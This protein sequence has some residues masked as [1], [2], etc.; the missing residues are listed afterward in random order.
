MVL[1]RNNHR[2]ERRRRVLLEE[3][4]LDESEAR[5]AGQEGTTRTS[6]GCAK[7]YTDSA[8]AI[9]QPRVVDLIPVRV[10]S[11]VVLTLLVTCL[12]VGIE[13]LYGYLALG[14][15][16]VR[17]GQVPA[18]DLAA[19][20][21]IANWFA[22]GLLLLAAGLGC[23]T[24]L[25][26][27]HRTDDYRG[28]YRMWYWVVPLVVLASVNQTVDWGTSLRIV[29][30]A[31]VGI[32]D[33][34]DATLIWAAIATVLATAVAVRLVIEMHASRLAVVFVVT[35][36]SSAGL[37]QAMQ[38]GWILG[39]DG[40]FQVMAA[41]G[42]RLL[43]CGTL[44][45]SFC[46]YSRHVHLE[47]H[48]QIVTKK[49]AQS[50]PRTRARRKSSAVDTATIAPSGSAKAESAKPALPKSM[51][52]KPASTKATEPALAGVQATPA[53]STSAAQRLAGMKVRVDAS[54]AE[55]AKTPSAPL[56]AE[57]IKRRVSAP[58]VAEKAPALAASHQD[59]DDSADGDSDDPNLSR[60]E[61]RR[62][63]KLQKRERRQ[64]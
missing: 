27:R 32:P 57:A 62:L 50:A 13:A 59:R 24:F 9:Y 36:W 54:H 18:F 25:M 55:P 64:G 21:N 10:W 8:L 40:V 53:A 12:G 43:A 5:D 22:G 60:S 35:A 14:D 7:P 3:P 44:L 23:L 41:S 34:P 63:K 17:L 49:R 28:R 2:D 15:G 45:L 1:H 31:A 38:L 33:Y 4:G 26:R 61:R 42:L 20:G 19:P 47:V 16:I 52:P 30:L 48:G 29:M 56:S 6:G 58:A 51:P 37:V 11:L 46:L 39:V